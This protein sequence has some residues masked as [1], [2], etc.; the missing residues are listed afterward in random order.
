MYS[1]DGT[2]K[3]KKITSTIGKAPKDF[4]S[5]LIKVLSVQSKSE[6]EERMIKFI[7]NSLQKI[8]N[9]TYKVEGKN[10]FVI[11]K[12]SDVTNFPAMVAH[13]DTVHEIVKDFKVF[14]NN[15][16]LFAFSGDDIKQ[17]GVGGDDKVGVFMTLEFLK[18]QPNMK[19]A[20]FW[21]EEIGCKGSK[22][23]DLK[24]W[25]D[26]GF[27]L[28]CDRKGNAD[29]IKS[30]SGTELSSREWLEAIKPILQKYE[31]SEEFGASTDVVALKDKGLNI[32]CANMSAGYYSP[33]SAKEIVNIQDVWELFHFCSEIFMAC[34][35]KK[36]LHEKKT[37]T[38]TNH[39]TPRSEYHGE[40]EGWHGH[41]NTRGNIEIPD[42]EEE[43]EETIAQGNECNKCGGTLLILNHSKLCTD[44]MNVSKIK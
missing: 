32:C 44:C 18:T 31:Y 10:I 24:F 33:H 19:A 42:E 23:S 22:A 40:W 1:F 43:E 34:G 41:R 28:Q 6:R 3:T 20:F 8:P 21:G 13:T 9:V 37:V 26:A 5:S 35:D 39:Y 15:N 4:I 11:K 17:A 30:A 12:T 38:Y 14:R 7:E 27:I 25:D 36:W 16:D 29:F 2:R